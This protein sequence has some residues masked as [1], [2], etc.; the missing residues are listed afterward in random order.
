MD[1]IATTISIYNPNIISLDMW[2]SHSLTSV[3]LLAMAKCQ[4]LE[5]V[6]FGWW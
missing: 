2:K 5:E 1:E 6:D 4:H 3:G